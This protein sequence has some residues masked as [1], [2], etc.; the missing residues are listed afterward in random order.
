MSGR[1]GV[2]M[3]TQVLESDLVRKSG[4]SPKRMG[5]IVNFRYAASYLTGG[6]R[7]PYSVARRGLGLSGWRLPDIH[8]LCELQ[9]VWLFQSA[10]SPL[11]PIIFRC[12]FCLSRVASH[13]FLNRLG[14]RVCA[15]SVLQHS[16]IVT[17]IL[18]V[19][20]LDL[21]QTRRPEGASIWLSG[22]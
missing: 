22:Q 14:C 13:L 7:A 19:L 20:R 17:T 8:T 12:T 9:V 2:L 18:C 4:S 6:M 11:M 5:K 3:D 1:F 21:A 15:S 10:P 16:E